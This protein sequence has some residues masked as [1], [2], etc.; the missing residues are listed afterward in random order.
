M[1]GNV[2]RRSATHG[3]F[4]WVP[5]TLLFS[6][7]VTG[8]ESMGGIDGCRA[9]VHI[10]TGTLPG[11]FWSLPVTATVFAVSAHAQHVPERKPRKKE[12]MVKQLFHILGLRHHLNLRFVLVQD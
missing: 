11:Q 10:G 9:L 12:G 3:L 1:Q 6:D 5:M 4:H 2:S 7:F 8:P